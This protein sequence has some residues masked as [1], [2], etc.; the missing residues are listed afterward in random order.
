[1]GLQRIQWN[2]N[3]RPAGGADP[4]V[5]AGPPGPA[6]SSIDKYQQ[7]ADVGVGLGPGGPP[8]FAFI[9]PRPGVFDG[10]L[11]ARHK[12]NHAQIDSE[13]AVVSGHAPGW[14]GIH[15]DV[16]FR[17]LRQIGFDDE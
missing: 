9:H 4:L 5:R 14:A 8:H 15:F 12:A 11:I 16:I 1:M 7:Q 13:D 6:T 10:A 3:L 2:D 17:A